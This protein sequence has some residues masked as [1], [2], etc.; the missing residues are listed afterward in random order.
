M[1]SILYM[2][3]EDGLFKTSIEIWKGGKDRDKEREVNLNWTIG[4]I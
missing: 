1:N 2:T 4:E 3:I